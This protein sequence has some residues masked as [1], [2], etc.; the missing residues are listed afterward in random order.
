CAFLTTPI[1]P[2]PPSVYRS[3]HEHHTS[4]IASV[5]RN[6]HCRVFHLRPSESP[7]HIP[8]IALGEKGSPSRLSLP[9]SISSDLSSIGPWSS[10]P[11][12]ASS[13]SP[14]KP[15]GQSPPVT[16]HNLHL[17]TRELF[18]SIAGCS[19]TAK[20]CSKLEGSVNVVY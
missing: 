13:I 12:S 14:G 4:H 7:I 10:V 9:Q 19:R 11:M 17:S 6:G 15:H 1:V 16:D 3:F 2:I 5:D 18:P 8:G 20:A